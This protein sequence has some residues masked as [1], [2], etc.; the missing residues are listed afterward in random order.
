MTTSMTA[1]P[2]LPESTLKAAT[3]RTKQRL[4]SRGATIAALENA[5]GT[6]RNL[7]CP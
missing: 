6:A 5:S 4:T 7:L 3:R 1:N 2:A